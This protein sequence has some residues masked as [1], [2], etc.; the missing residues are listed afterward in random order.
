M[1][2]KWFFVPLLCLSLLGALVFGVSASA[3]EA[4]TVRVGA[5]ENEPKI[6]TDETGKVS[7]FWPDIIEYVAAEEGWQIEYVPGTWTECL[8]RLEAGEIDIMPD[9][10]YTEE[11]GELYAFAG[12]M[13]YVSWS[14]V[15]A[16]EGADIQSILDLAGKRV[17]VLEGSVNVEGVGGIKELVRS[18]DIDC[19]FIELDSYIQVFELVESGEADAGVAS[20]DFAYRHQEEFDLAKT[21]IVFQAVPLYFA[22]PK[23]ADLT[24]Y[25]IE[26]IDAL[27]KE[28]KAD[29]GSIYYQALERW[30]GAQLVEKTVVPGWVKWVLIGIGAA[31]LV[32]VGGNRLLRS[33]VKAR[34]KELTE[35]I[36]ERRQAQEALA[37]SE[38]KY[39][40]LVGN[41]PN[42][43]SIVQ[44]GKIKFA[45]RQVE[46]ITGYSLEELQ[47]MDPFDI[48][49]PKDRVVLQDYNIR[50]MK[51]E[52]VPDVYSLR[53]IHKDGS[54]RWLGRR[55]T[56]VTWDGKP[57]VLVMDGDI[58]ER[59]QTEITLSESEE[60]CKAIFEAATDGILLAD[61]A[62]KRF[63]DGNEAICRMTGYSLAELKNLGVMNLHPKE[64]VPRILKDFENQ[65][66]GIYSLVLDIP[67]K[68]K[69]GSVFYADINTAPVSFGGK[70]YLMGMFRDATERRKLEAVVRAS[71]ERLQL[72]FQSVSEGIVCS[73]LEGKI[74]D[75]NKVALRMFGYDRKEDAIGRSLFDFIVV[76]DHDRVRENMQKM[77]KTGL[78]RDIEYTFLR[79]DGSE[80]PGELSA[81]VLKDTDGSPIGLVAVVSDITERKK[82]QEQLILTDRLAS[83]GE[84][85]SGIA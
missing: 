64:D 11:R 23:G 49:H 77:L 27:M 26:R 54:T 18:F 60:R 71:R 29:E 61:V 63:H 50:R 68:R 15:Y 58:T 79:K 45:N 7:G 51:G 57:A 42:G 8:E 72:M 25:F 65:A 21:G 32:L 34:T 82:M 76:T 83:I 30:L 52:P 2:R 17:A 47:A 78:S 43:V 20:K 6:F 46:K 14:R 33:Q 10:A 39:R 73:D 12:E 41:V 5:Y 53:I 16:R 1:N 56:P 22:F 66:R 85:S 19:T 24:P 44:D 62:G 59:R 67:V 48:V 13:S 31:V 38:Y 9:V 75:T 40:L 81:S 84:V 3:D 80:F 70:T 28:L 4:L 36:S 69:D 74:G 55:V 35:E 37:E